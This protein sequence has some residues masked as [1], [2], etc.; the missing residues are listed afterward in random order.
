MSRTA[1]RAGVTE[2]APRSPKSRFFRQRPGTW[3]QQ[4]RRVVKTSRVVPPHFRHGE[5]RGV[6]GLV[7]W[8]R[9]PEG[10]RAF[11]REIF[12][13]C[14]APVQRCRGSVPGQPGG[15]PQTRS[16]AVLEVSEL[17]FPAPAAARCLLPSFRRG[18]SN[19]LCRRH[20]GDLFASTCADEPQPKVGCPVPPRQLSW[21]RRSAE[22]PAA[23]DHQSGAAV[24]AIAEPTPDGGSIPLAGEGPGCRRQKPV[25]GRPVQ[26]C[27][28]SIAP[29]P[30]RHFSTG[31][32]MSR[33]ASAASTV[34]RGDPEQPA[35]RL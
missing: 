16:A 29:V 22:A 31:I 17:S 13:R 24:A 18:S 23:A 28:C 25:R 6:T 8:L 7:C 14:Q 2:P 9:R 4:R 15:I 21:C 27:R 30:G 12:R 26:P 32:S 20:Q 5:R 3:R 11:R 10:A 35:H 33:A 1:G 34:R 19:R